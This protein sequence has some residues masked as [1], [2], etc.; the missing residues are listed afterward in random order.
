MT[1]LK[2]ELEAVQRE[3]DERVIHLKQLSMAKEKCIAVINGLKGK[4][5]L[6]QKLLKEQQK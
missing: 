6:L 5:E 2:K 3:H 1:N 4:I